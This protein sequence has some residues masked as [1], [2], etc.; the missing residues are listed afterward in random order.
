MDSMDFYIQGYVLSNED[1]G[2][3]LITNTFLDFD[4]ASG[5]YKLTPFC[6]NPNATILGDIML[7]GNTAIMTKKNTR[8]LYSYITIRGP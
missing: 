5:G 7:I 8:L 2:L 6:N 4:S 3:I 1:P